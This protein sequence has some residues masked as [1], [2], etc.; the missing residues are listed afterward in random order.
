MS[1][2]RSSSDNLRRKRTLLVT[3]Y[4]DNP[5]QDHQRTPNKKHHQS[6]RPS[7]PS[8]DIEDYK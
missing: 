6:D 5:E 1:H 8:I 2:T 3:D 7:N 4:D